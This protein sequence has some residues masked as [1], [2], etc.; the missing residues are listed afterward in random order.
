M[1]TPDAKDVLL[2]TTPTL[3]L[4]IPAAGLEPHTHIVQMGKLRPFGFLPYYIQHLG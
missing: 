4:G 2:T 3:P 1:L